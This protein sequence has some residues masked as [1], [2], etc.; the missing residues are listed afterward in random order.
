MNDELDRQGSIRTPVIEK[1]IEEVKAR[2]NKAL[3]PIAPTVLNY[4]LVHSFVIT[5]ITEKLRNIPLDDIITPRL[6]IAAPALASVRYLGRVEE[7]KELYAS[8]IATS[9]DVNTSTSVHPCFV[10]F[11]LQLSSD[12]ARLLAAFLNANREPLI[13]IRNMRRDGSGGSDYYMYFTD[14]HERYGTKFPEYMRNYFDNFIRLGI[15]DIPENHELLDQGVYDALEA[16]PDVVAMRKEINNEPGRRYAV[17]RTAI[18]LTGLGRQFVEC[19]VRDRR[20]EPL[21]VSY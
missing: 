20:N 5:R 18:R 6:H 13:N 11:I 14:L 19:C 9:M 10:H 1:D 8:L 7:L 3:E 4:E 21:K 12:E 17:T 2:V 15:A 16:H